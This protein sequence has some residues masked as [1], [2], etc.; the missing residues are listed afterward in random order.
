MSTV[1]N[2]LLAVFLTLTAVCLSVCLSVC[3]AG[4]NILPVLSFNTSRSMKYVKCDTPVFI[5]T[6]CSVKTH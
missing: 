5:P 1:Q 3:I 2:L 4:P 6:L